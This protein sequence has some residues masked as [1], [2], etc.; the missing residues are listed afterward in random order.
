MSVSF[1]QWLM[2]LVKFIHKEAVDSERVIELSLLSACYKVNPVWFCFFVLNIT[3]LLL[4]LCDITAHLIS[5][6]DDKLFHPKMLLMVSDIFSFS[7]IYYNMWLFVRDVWTE[8]RSD[9]LW[10]TGTDKHT[11]MDPEQQTQILILGLSFHPLK[12]C[13]L[14]LF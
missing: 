7:I 3:L 13:S 14:L 12:L 1:S 11:K 8:T 10:A 9:F 6:L 5:Q 2:H 4:L